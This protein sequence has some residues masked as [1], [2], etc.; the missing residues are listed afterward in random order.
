MKKICKECG[1]FK[2]CPA[3]GLCRKCYDKKYRRDKILEY[4][5]SYYL[6]NHEERKASRRKYY[7]ENSEKEKAKHRKYYLENKEKIKVY[8]KKYYLENLEKIKAYNQ[9]N[10]EKHKAFYRKYYLENKRNIKAASKK[11]R[12][13]NPEK[14]KAIGKKYRLENPGKTREHKIK[15]RGYGTPKNGILD[16]VITENILKYG[17][18]VCEKCKEKCP[19]NFHIDHIRPVSKGGSNDYD[20]LQILCA[21]CN[22]KKF[23]KTANY[24]QNIKDSQVYLREVL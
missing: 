2:E 8:D 1:E 14:V 5:K 13:E 10:S 16:K 18:I 3:R 20:N 12:K 21:D 15:R 17:E 19:N 4:A 7:H 23:T 6:K 22:H 24:K 11:Y 9:E